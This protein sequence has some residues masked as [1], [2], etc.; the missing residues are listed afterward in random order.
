MGEQFY[1]FWHA[2]YNDHEIIASQAALTNLVEQFADTEHGDAFTSRQ[3]RDALN[4]D[5]TP[6]VLIDEDGVSIR[7]IVFTKW[8]GFY[9]A[10]YDLS[11]EAPHQLVNLEMTNLV[12][13]DID[14][15]F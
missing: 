2:F 6:R 5:P 10:I 3:K 11:T 7:V 1:L 8:G 9:E 4:I 15:M 12:P 13:Y 14:I